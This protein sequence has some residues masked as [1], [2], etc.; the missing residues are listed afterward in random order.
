MLTNAPA[1][2]LLKAIAD[3]T[4]SDV[5][6]IAITRAVAVQIYRLIYVKDARSSQPG[7]QGPDQGS[8]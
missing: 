5:P 7:R 4:A 2:E 6:K 3:G 8:G 1:V